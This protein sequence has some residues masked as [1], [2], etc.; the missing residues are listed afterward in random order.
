MVALLLLIAAL[1]AVAVLIGPRTPMSVTA[2][3]ALAVSLGIVPLGM[4]GFIWLWTRNARLFLGTTYFGHADVL[5]RRTVFP[6]SSLHRIQECHVIYRGRSPTPLIYLLDADGHSLF[7]LGREAWN[8]D[9]VDDYLN[10]LGLPIETDPNPIK[11]KD[12][13][14]ELRESKST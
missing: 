2:A 7:Q 6:L 5:A 14:K 11:W 10:R 4:I 13:K 12:L 1:V 8:Q 9:K 3:M